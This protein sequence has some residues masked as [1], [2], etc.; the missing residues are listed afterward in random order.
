M[1]YRSVKRFLDWLD[2]R[3]DKK[4]ERQI[5]LSQ[6]VATA[7]ETT[8][9]AALEALKEHT[10]LMKM[11]LTG[12]NAL[13]TP[14]EKPFSSV[15]R[16]EDEFQQEVERIKARNTDAMTPVWQAELDF[17]FLKDIE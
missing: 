5:R 6:A 17:D 12:L 10:A 9:L 4:L 8:A 7:N 14:G 13:S 11:W 1:F 2:Q 16:D 3:R 15:V